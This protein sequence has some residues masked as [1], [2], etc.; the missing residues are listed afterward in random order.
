MT[1]Y[2]KKRFGTQGGFAVTL[3]FVVSTL[4]GLCSSHQEMMATRH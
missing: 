2:R 4:P 1:P 3:V